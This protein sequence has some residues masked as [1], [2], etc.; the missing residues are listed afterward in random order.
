MASTPAAGSTTMN[1][2]PTGEGAASKHSGRPVSPRLLGTAVILVASIWFIVVNW[3]TASIYLWVPK[4]TA[5]MWLVLLTT[6]LG[7]LVTGILTRRTGKKP[8]QD[9]AQTKH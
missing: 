8:Q 7:G 2:T 5:P 4:V 6:F 1:G 9:Q 3:H